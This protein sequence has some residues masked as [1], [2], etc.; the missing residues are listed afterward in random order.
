MP[1][2]PR[3]EETAATTATSSAPTAASGKNAHVVSCVS[4]AR[5]IDGGFSSFQPRDAAAHI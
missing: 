2:P 4:R 3:A 5:S 1:T